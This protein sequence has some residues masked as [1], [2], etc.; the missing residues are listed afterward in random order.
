MIKR[1]LMMLGVAILCALLAF[2][3]GFCLVKLECDIQLSSGEIAMNAE[4]AE[5]NG[6]V[7]FVLCLLG[8]SLSLA[9]IVL[10][11]SICFFPLILVLDKL[12]GTE[13]DTENIYLHGGWSGW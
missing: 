5:I 13:I 12:S 7:V 9:A 11:A 10:L 1:A 8:G 3:A 4:D 6:L 2:L